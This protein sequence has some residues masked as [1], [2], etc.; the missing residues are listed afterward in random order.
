MIREI[1]V[2]IYLDNEYV[3]YGSI[4]YED[5]SMVQLVDTIKY[6]C[7]KQQLCIDSDCYSDAIE[8]CY[9]DKVSSF[10]GGLDTKLLEVNVYDAEGNVVGEAVLSLYDSYSPSIIWILI[11]LA[12]LWAQSVALIA[13]LAFVRKR[14]GETR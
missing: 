3:G 7:V 5:E 10:F 14:V 2:T 9:E 11:D 8:F 6:K 13:V 12:F 1:P 4:I